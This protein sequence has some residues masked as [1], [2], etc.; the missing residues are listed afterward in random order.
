MVRVCK[1]D[2]EWELF[3]D[4]GRKRNGRVAP[5][6]R[7]RDGRTRN[8]YEVASLPEGRRIFRDLKRSLDV[9]DYTWMGAA[10]DVRW[11]AADEAKLGMQMGL[12]IL[13]RWSP[14]LLDTGVELTPHDVASM[15]R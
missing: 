14:D 3:A 4:F 15:G 11:Q 5:I 12:E 6:F 13:G 1:L 9:M 2:K 8:P 7:H 10:R